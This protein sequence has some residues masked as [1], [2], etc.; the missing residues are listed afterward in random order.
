MDAA[1]DPEYL[2]ATAQ[3]VADFKDA[4]EEFLSLHETN[5]HFARGLA[6][7]ELPR[8]DADP[9][10]IKE[11]RSKVARAAGRA[12]YAPGLTNAYIHVEG[13][14]PI[15]P[16]AAW[17]SMTSP[18]P[19]LEADNV[20]EMCDQI[21]GRLEAM[22]RKAE[23]E[24]PSVSGVEHFHPLVWGAASRL[25]RNEHYREAV[26]S[27]AEALV[28]HVQSRTGRHDVAAT[29]LWQQ[30]FSSAPPK[31]GDPKLRWPGE[32]TSQT[33]KTMNEGLRSFAPGVQMT[34]RNT[35]AHGTDTMN[36]Q[37]ALERLAALS[38]LARWI[39]DCD[40]VTV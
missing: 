28:A 22:A 16:M 35:S 14:G 23:A 3:A 21:L 39:D 11:L 5:H 2:Q 26:A 34:I 32:P 4:L 19:L 12:S 33:V 27:A 15:D 10:E 24:A 38:L 40:D 17:S 30:V 29:S 25:W 8:N 6:P 20:L 9:I 36:A 13:H 1:R 7:A 18:K 31:P 37:D